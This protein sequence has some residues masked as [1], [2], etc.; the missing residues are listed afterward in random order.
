MLEMPDIL[1]LLKLCPIFILT[2]YQI[3][4]LPTFDSEISTL[5]IN[6][7]INPYTV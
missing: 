2:S 3:W 6:E 1:Y 5:I 4:Y 7:L